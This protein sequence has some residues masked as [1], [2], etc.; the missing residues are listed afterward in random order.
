MVV[1][2]CVRCETCSG[3]GERKL[4]VTELDT[5][6]AVGPDWCT[7]AEIGKRIRYP[8]N[9]PHPALCNRLVRLERL[10]LVER[11]PLTGKVYEWR[12]K[13]QSRRAA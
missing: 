2:T 9:I 3:S 10:G 6:N 8:R 7:A 4:S 12:I 13:A 11:R 5:Y 1:M